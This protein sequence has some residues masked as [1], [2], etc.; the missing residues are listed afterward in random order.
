[1]TAGFNLRR[2]FIIIVTTVG[3]LICFRGWFFGCFLLREKIKNAFFGDS[4]L[5]DGQS[6]KTTMPLET[7]RA[8]HA[9]KA[10]RGVLADST[11]ISSETFGKSQWT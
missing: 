11:W 5:K 8:L 3:F 1:V 4:Q 10:A 7:G 6:V 2:N 9:M